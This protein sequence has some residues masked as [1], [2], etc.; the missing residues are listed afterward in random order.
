MRCIFFPF[1]LSQLVNQ[2][3]VV[4]WL[5]WFQGIPLLMQT[6][7]SI[8]APKTSGILPSHEWRNTRKSRKELKKCFLR[9]H[10]SPYLSNPLKF[11]HFITLTHKLISFT[12]IFLTYDWCLR[13]ICI[14]PCS[15]RFVY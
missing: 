9:N 5:I 12:T 11:R 3:I 10:L 4:D 15:K 6:T 14:L 13:R 8:Q 1:L 7:H 2:D